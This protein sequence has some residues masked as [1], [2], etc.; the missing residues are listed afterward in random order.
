MSGI[1][2]TARSTRTGFAP[3]RLDTEGRTEKKSGSD[4]ETQGKVSWQRWFTY[5]QGSGYIIQDTAW[6]LR[7]V[8]Q[9]VA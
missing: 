1:K 2:D 8:W 7:P 5:R 6:T 3:R 4:F 9:W